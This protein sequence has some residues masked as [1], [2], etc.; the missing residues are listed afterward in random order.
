MYCILGVGLI[1]GLASV[2]S[3]VSFDLFWISVGY[4]IVDVLWIYCGCGLDFFCICSGFK[5][6]IVKISS[7]LILDLIWV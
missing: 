1:L 7:E 2:F 4:K 3:A 5:F 6:D